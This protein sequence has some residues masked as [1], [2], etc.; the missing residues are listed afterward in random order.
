MTGFV[1]FAVHYSMPAAALHGLCGIAF[2]LLLPVPFRRSRP[3]KAAGAVVVF[4]ACLVTVP[5]ALS[6]MNNET[7]RLAHKLD[8]EGPAA[9]TTQECLGI[10]LL[11]LWTAGVGFLVYP[12]A[13]EELFYLYLPAEDDRRHFESD[14]ATASARVRDP[15]ARFSN[16]LSTQS[17]LKMPARRVAW[18]SYSQSYDENRVAFALNPCTL[19]AE[20]HRNGGEWTIHVS[21]ITRIEFPRRSRVVVARI[22][23][24][25][26]K[27]EE[28]LFW[29]LQQRGWLHP[30]TAKWTWVART[31]T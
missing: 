4:G 16:S 5:V 23:A 25:Q 18:R 7:D 13:A 17:T 20:A 19:S 12:E 6:E 27:L 10:Y 31:A 21:A 2:L 14:F 24:H 30:Y 22:G 28:G 8:R 3:V 26:L 9:L 11:G 1:L 29:A 15:L